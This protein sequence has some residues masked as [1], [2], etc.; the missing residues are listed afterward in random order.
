MSDELYQAIIVDHARRAHPLP[1]GDRRASRDNPFCGDA[2]TV[3]VQ[4]DERGFIAAIGYSADGCAIA[5]ASASMMCAAA[6]GRDSA[7]VAALRRE[8]E[9]LL[10]G[11]ATE[12]PGDLGA[13]AGVAR[14]PVRKKCATLPWDAL[15]DT[16]GA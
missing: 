2:V 9:R 11:E 7:G 10:A 1:A 6:A 16:L 4:L 15:R 14:Y 3:G 13:L 8:L 12:L 5:K